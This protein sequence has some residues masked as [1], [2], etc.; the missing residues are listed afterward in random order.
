MAAPQPPAAATCKR[1]IPCSR[2]YRG[3]HNVWILVTGW[4]WVNGWVI[5][6]T[7]NNQQV[8]NNNRDQGGRN[9]TPIMVGKWL[10]TRVEGIRPSKFEYHIGNWTSLCIDIMLSLFMILQPN[11]SP[12]QKRLSWW[13]FI[14]VISVY[15]FCG[16]II[17]LR[18]R[19]PWGLHVPGR[20]AD[21][22]LTTVTLINY[23]WFR[24]LMSS[25]TTRNW[26]S[27]QS[28]IHWLYKLSGNWIHVFPYWRSFPTTT[29]R[30]STKWPSLHT[31]RHHWPS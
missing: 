10:V 13:Y 14:S 9:R 7:N 3:D 5:T 11:T 12:H 20:I 1:R 16:R 28:Q 29:N 21:C 8:T 31:I 17:P 26:Y 23:H 19:R 15:C 24:L 25:K 18:C 2:S 4:W 27:N 30:Q 6:L 22:L